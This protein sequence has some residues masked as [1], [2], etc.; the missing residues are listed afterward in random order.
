MVSWPLITN[1]TTEYWST[2]MSKQI[3]KSLPQESI[4]APKSNLKIMFQPKGM[5]KLILF[6]SYLLQI[7]QLIL[8]P[9]RRVSVLRSSTVQSMVWIL[10]IT[11][12]VT[13]LACL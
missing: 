8:I 5:L 7:Y 9:A 4:P 3:L 6:S 10:A 1:Q 12:E 11:A 13:S 2:N